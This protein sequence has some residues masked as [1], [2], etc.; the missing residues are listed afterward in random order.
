MPSYKPQR[1]TLGFTHEVPIVKKEVSVIH[2]SALKGMG[3]LYAFNVF[4]K[5]H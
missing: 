1:N 2:F 3:N 4:S 5:I